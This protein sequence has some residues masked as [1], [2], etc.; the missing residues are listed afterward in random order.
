[1]ITRKLIKLATQLEYMIDSL[2]H[3]NSLHDFRV[4]LARE[5]FV[6]GEKPNCNAVISRQ[7]TGQLQEWYNNDTL[8]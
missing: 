6:F 5:I 8:A 4:C 1:M 7:I 3:E 2:E